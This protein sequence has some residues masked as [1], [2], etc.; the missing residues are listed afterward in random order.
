MD[1][2]SNTVHMKLLVTKLK[3]L[4]LPMANIVPPAHTKKVLSLQRLYSEFCPMP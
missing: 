2:Q 1:N 3:S 4:I